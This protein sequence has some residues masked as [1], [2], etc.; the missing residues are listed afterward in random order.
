MWWLPSGESF[1]SSSCSHTCKDWCECAGW[2][3]TRSFPRNCSDHGQNMRAQINWL[4]GRRWKDV[5]LI[6]NKVNCGSLPGTLKCFAIVLSLKQV[7]GMWVF[8]FVPQVVL[9]RTV[10]FTPH[11]NFLLD[12]HPVSPEVIVE[13]PSDQNGYTLVVTGKKVRP[14]SM[15]ISMCMVL[16]K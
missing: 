8:P 3:I 1:D 6:S 9:S 2:L 5:A 13:H 10:P 11:V 4:P 16:F 14:V 7:L 12:S 15:G